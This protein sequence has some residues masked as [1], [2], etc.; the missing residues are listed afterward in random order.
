MGTLKKMALTVIMLVSLLISQ[1]SHAEFYKWVD[2]K[3]TV[4]FT[5]DPNKV[6]KKYSD[7]VSERTEDQLKPL[8]NVEIHDNAEGM[9]IKRREIPQRKERVEEREE[10]EE[11]VQ[12][13]EECHSP[14]QTDISFFLPRYCGGARNPIALECQQILKRCCNYNETE[15]AEIADKGAKDRKGKIIPGKIP[16]LLRWYCGATGDIAPDHSP[17]IKVRITK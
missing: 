10:R 15:F 13:R 7:T 17:G 16:D 4:H 14:G 2:E 3:G 8:G 11:R 6:P 9:T 1:S 5:D 12:K